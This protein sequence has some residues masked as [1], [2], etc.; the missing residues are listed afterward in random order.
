MEH[1]KWPPLVLD[2]WEPTYL[3]LHR[4][5]QIAGKVR[6][7]L[8]PR[9]NHWWHVP[10]YVSSRGLTTSS[11]P[12]GER[13]L[14][15]T[16]DFCA[17]RFN[18]HTNDNRIEGFELEP[19]S[20]AEFY[21]R[22]MRLLE[23]LDMPTKVNPIPSEMADKTPLSEDHDHAS[24]DRV[25]VTR[26]HRILVSTSNVFHTHRARFLGKSSPVH[27]FW[28]GFDLAV[29]RFSGRRNPT[30]PADA[31][32]RDAYS[33]E[34]ISHGFWP[35]GSWPLGGRVPDAVFY[36]Y[37]VPPPEGFSTARVK[38][39]EA[40]YSETF[41]EFFLPYAAMRTSDDPDAALLDFMESTYLAAAERAGWDI[42]AFRYA[43]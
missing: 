2:D 16:F 42:E 5:T 27:F 12:Y 10:L 11:M 18:A 29:T 3:T 28:G 23:E 35:G 14:T 40:H 15:L 39:K 33:H 1:S 24:Y 41:G 7:A 37:S 13:T 17:H 32:N 34:V 36:A 20:V 9:A 31:I 38:P 19:M 22:T 21:R 4:W 43:M 25:A 6:L 30:P 26:L 8:A